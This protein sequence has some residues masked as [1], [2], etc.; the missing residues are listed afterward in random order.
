MDSIQYKQWE[1]D[2]DR[3]LSGKYN[4]EEREIILEWFRRIKGQDE[5]D[6]IG[7]DGVEAMLTFVAAAD[8]FDLYN[9]LMAR[10][11]IYAPLILREEAAY[12][13]R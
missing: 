11:F 7:N 5:R 10:L 2:A 4:S 3:A 1:T 13:A 6:L 8:N 12:Q 9:S